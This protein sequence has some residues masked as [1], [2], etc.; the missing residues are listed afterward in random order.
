MAQQARG[1]DQHW[2]DPPAGLLGLLE[3]PPKYLI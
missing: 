2:H 3:Y 1:L